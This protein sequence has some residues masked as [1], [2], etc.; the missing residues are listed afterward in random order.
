MPG[1]PLLEIGR[2]ARPHGLS[3]E[4]L[5]DLVTNVPERMAAGSELVAR[6]AAGREVTVKVVASR[7]HQRRLL[8]SL[9]HVLDREEAER[10]KGATLFAEALES[11]EETLFVHEL[12]GCELVESSGRSRGKVVSVQA[13][14]ASDLLVGEEGW[15]V[16]LRFVVRRGEGVIVVDGPEGL[17]E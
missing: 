10:L 16:P 1:R 14:P 5:V 12:I 6:D 15:L 13:N 4:V 7:A 8:V 9:E 17:F 3:G 11:T 2:I